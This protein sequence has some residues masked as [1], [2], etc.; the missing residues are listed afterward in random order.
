MLKQIALRSMATAATGAVVGARA[1]QRRIAVV[2]AGS[3]GGWTALYLL[4][5]GA[6][7]TL[8][9]TWGPGNTRSSSGGETRVIRS[10]YGADRIYIQLIK[11]AFQLWQQAGARWQTELY[12]R[13]GL[14]WL[15]SRDDAYARDSLPILQQFGI[16]VDSLSLVDARRRFPQ[17]DFAGVQ[18]CY[19]EPEAGYLL[20]RLS[21]RLVRDHFQ[22]EGGELRDAEAKPG[23]VRAGSMQGLLLS[24][25]SRLSADQ[26]VFAC[27]PWLGRLFPDVREAAIQPSRQEVYF[28]GTPP[29]NTYQEPR[30]PI[31]VD[32][33][34]RLIYGIPGA[35]HRGFKLADDTRGEPF[36]PTDGDRSPSG[37]GIR[38]AR[39]F[40]ARRFPGLR[41]AP[42]LE[43]RVCQYENSLDGNFIIDRHPEA[44][45]VW[46]VG[47]GSG[48]GFKFGP[49]L[50]E[51]VAARVL[52]D[53]QIDSFFA[54]G[55]LA[56]IRDKRTQFERKK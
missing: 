35:E 14:L 5:A 27:G 52:G 47:G 53:A 20:A 11:R 17:I 3:F 13:T 43:A 37:D 12:R 23:Q 51:Y 34:E 7:V 28:F 1:A 21:C 45:N 38:R 26:Y 30:L 40:L 54:L 46:L 6:Q 29:G 18:A 9:D 42:L 41:T 48:H 50:G 55:R 31:W 25:G 19:F 8:V 36:D 15:F 2:G 4:R 33:G 44:R 32:F 10:I 16:H 22:R 56:G 39:D 49:A 24:D